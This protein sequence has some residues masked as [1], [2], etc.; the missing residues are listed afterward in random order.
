M[1]PI[2]CLKWF[3]L[4]FS[5]GQKWCQLD[6]WS[7]LLATYKKLTSTPCGTAR[8]FASHFVPPR[9]LHG[10]QDNVASAPCGTA[11]SCPSR[12]VPPRTLQGTQD[13]VSP[14]GKPAEVCPSRFVP[15]RTLQ[16][17]QDKVRTGG[18]NSQSPRLVQN[19]GPP[20]ACPRSQISSHS[21]R[22]FSQRAA[23]AALDHGQCW[24]HH[25]PQ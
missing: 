9:T 11:P 5:G 7:P 17:T 13:N 2:G 15:P 1:V 3:P 23:A 6:F 25:A 22:T 18:G 4:H 20:E 12:F 24:A 10:T 16:G 14:S 8:V 19:G 21:S